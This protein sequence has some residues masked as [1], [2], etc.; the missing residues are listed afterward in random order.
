M[1][2]RKSK[3]KP[4]LNKIQT[5]GVGNIC[6]F[7]RLPCRYLDLLGPEFSTAFIRWWTTNQTFS[8]LFDRPKCYRAL[9]GTEF[10]W[11]Q[12]KSL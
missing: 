4:G 10:D 7:D 2:K 3:N 6:T 5:D 9:Q 1:R 12:V 11:K 8:L